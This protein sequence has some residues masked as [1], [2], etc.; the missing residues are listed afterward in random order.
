MSRFDDLE[1][2][3]RKI[4]LGEDSLLELKQVA[5]RR[6][7][8]AVAIGTTLTVALVLLG[9]G[10][11]VEAQRPE[12]SRAEREILARLTW[13][14][15][16][17][18]LCEFVNRGW[19]ELAWL[20]QQTERPGP[21]LA[22]EN[23]GRVRDH[24]FA[25]T[26]WRHLMPMFHEGCLG[27][28]A[29]L[30]GNHGRTELAPALR[31]A[32]RELA[33]S[34]AAM[35]EM[36]GLEGSAP[37]HALIAALRDFGDVDFLDQLYGAE[38]EGAIASFEG[39]AAVGF[40][41]HAAAGRLTR[42]S[43]AGL[44]RRLIELR[45]VNGWVL[46]DQVPLEPLLWG[47]PVQLAAGEELRVLLH[48]EGHFGG[49][50]GLVVA[51]RGRIGL[52]PA[53][54]VLLAPRPTAGEV[55]ARRDEGW[56][57]QDWPGLVRVLQ[58]LRL[59]SAAGL[60]AVAGPVPL[61]IAR[62]LVELV[63]YLRSGYGESF[64]SRRISEIRAADLSKARLPELV[65]HFAEGGWESLGDSVAI[66]SFPDGAGP[67]RRIWKQRLSYENEI[68]GFQ[69]TWH[70]A[71]VDADRNREL[72]LFEGTLELSDPERRASTWKIRFY[73]L[74]GGRYRERAI[75]QGVREHLRRFYRETGDP[76]EQTIIRSHFG[77]PP[78]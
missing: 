57:R 6:R 40:W 45:P 13:E 53:G 65:V 52:T 28:A 24:F 55:A 3:T 30:I 19:R 21:P 7:V 48:K 67:A 43:R 2:L 34:L 39:S 71:E 23:L 62:F 9:A 17:S 64:S 20:R 60:D 18:S 69:V 12:I 37:A 25:S 38:V 32:L 4:R 31:A 61:P 10:A 50:D 63:P 22:E 35:D 29:G 47:P 77:G 11:S 54:S 15:D 42:V 33:P 46:S 44:G 72:L 75:H 74:E 26:A 76:L 70:D 68:E 58:E 59:L 14:T 5:F 8:V 56:R 1:A 66:F 16:D 41:S 73:D 51:T 36:R 49:L 78:S 27:T